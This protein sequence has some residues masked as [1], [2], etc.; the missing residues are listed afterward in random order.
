MKS[1]KKVFFGTYVRGFVSF[2]ALFTFTGAFFLWLP[3]SSAPGENVSFIDAL[4]VS[5]SGMST[6]GLSTIS[7]ADTL[8]VFGKVILALILQFGGIGLIMLLAIIW[9]TIGKRIS[10]KERTMI[11]TDQNQV[12]MSGVVKLVKNVLFILF[13]V[14]LIAFI[15]MGTYLWLSGYFPANQAYAQAAFL[16]VS[17][18]TNA[19]FDITGD[20]L[21]RYNDDYFMQSIAMFLMFVGAVGF[22]VLVEFKEWLSAF[23]KKKK[24]EFSIFVKTIVSMHILLWLF[25]ALFVF[26][27]EYNNTPFILQTYKENGYNPLYDPSQIDFAFRFFNSLFMSLTTRNAGFATLEMQDFSGATKMFFSFLMFTGS[28][29]N[30]AGGGVRTT[31]FIISLLALYSY[32]IGRKQVVLKGRAI[33]QETVLKSFVV[34]LGAMVVVVTSTI[35]LLLTDSHTLEQSFFEVTSA[36]GT[37]GLSLGITGDLSFFSKLVLI[38]TMFVGRVG[39]LSLL[40]LMKGDRDRNKIKYPETDLIVG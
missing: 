28:S 38:G 24:Y 21:F 29:P 20:S 13:S 5:V 26:I 15:I 12:K 7:V 6:T 27:V 22:W 10:F 25:G 11:M 35:L 14:E 40:L 4:F 39:I 37:T 8:S 32:S 16:T 1:L 18:I 31:T 19:G 34:I 2:Y 23:L 36:F 33:K 17:M 30:S 3:I 9:I